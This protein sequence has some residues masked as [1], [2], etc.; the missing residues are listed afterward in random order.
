MS[1]TLEI[2]EWILGWGADVE[3][4]EPEALRREIGAIVHAAA[5]RYPRG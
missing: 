5:A 4:L 1:G 3:V 2:R